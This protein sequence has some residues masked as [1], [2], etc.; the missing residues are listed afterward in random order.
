MV[1]FLHNIIQSPVEK[2]PQNSKEIGRSWG[3]LSTKT[4]SGMNKSVV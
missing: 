1:V 4:I 3:F 2:I